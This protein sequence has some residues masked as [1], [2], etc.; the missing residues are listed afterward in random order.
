MTEDIRAVVPGRSRS[1]VRGDHSA[2]ANQRAASGATYTVGHVVDASW[3][4]VSG[5]A[6]GQH[7]VCTAPVAS[8]SPIDTATAG[9]HKLTV[10]NDGTPV[11]VSCTVVRRSPQRRSLRS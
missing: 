2:S 7:I 1:P 8:G 6:S 11:T 10:T 9:V 3:S 4:C 5:S